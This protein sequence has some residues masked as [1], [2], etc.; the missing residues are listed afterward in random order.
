MKKDKIETGLDFPRSPPFLCKKMEKVAA[1]VR[2]GLGE[3]G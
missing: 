1:L 2:R 3:G